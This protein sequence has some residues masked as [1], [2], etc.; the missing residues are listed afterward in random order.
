MPATGE[1]RR[2]MGDYQ[3]HLAELQKI[4]MD[5]EIVVPPRLHEGHLRNPG[6]KERV[7]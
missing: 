2:L 5:R 4:L 7:R 3:Q 6:F 1:S